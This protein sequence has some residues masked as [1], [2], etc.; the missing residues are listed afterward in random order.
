MGKLDSSLRPIQDC[1][2][3]CKNFLLW[4]PEFSFV[5]GG[6]YDFKVFFQQYVIIHDKA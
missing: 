1:V 6:T 5:K 2:T 4:V 3:L